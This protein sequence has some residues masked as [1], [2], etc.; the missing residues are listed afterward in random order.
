MAQKI[1]KQPHVAF[2]IYP[3]ESLTIDQAGSLF[4]SSGMKLTSL[5]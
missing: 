1:A 2:T 5:K 3:T 4:L